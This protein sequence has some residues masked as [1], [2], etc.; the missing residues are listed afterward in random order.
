[1]TDLLLNNECSQ[2]SRSINDDVLA[3]ALGEHRLPV[4]TDLPKKEAYSCISPK[5]CVRISL[6]RLYSCICS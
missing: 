5:V 2:D 3:L 1:M 4:C 6:K